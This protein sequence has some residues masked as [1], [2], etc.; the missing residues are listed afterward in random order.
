MKIMKKMKSR[1]LIF[2]NRSALN[3]LNANIKLVD[4][5]KILKEDRDFYK[6][7]VLDVLKYIK[8]HSERVDINIPS[9]PDHF[10]S[11]TGNINIIKEMLEEINGSNK[12]I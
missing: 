11:F 10:I 9:M 5:N 7:K 3:I 12:N 2:D 8:E 1:Q 4:E 6:N